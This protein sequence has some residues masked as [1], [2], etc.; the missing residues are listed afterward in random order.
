MHYTS[1]KLLSRVNYK[2][3]TTKYLSPE[4]YVITCGM[5][6]GFTL[7]IASNLDNALQHAGI[8]VPHNLLQH[9]ILAFGV[10]LELE[11]GTK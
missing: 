9:R 7:N 5:E 10:I 11:V 4:L 8:V 6:G 2:G 1:I 3:N